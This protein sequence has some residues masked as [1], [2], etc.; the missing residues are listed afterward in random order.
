MMAYCGPPDRGNEQSHRYETQ[1][2]EKR[3]FARVRRQQPKGKRE[4]YR[5]DDERNLEPT[6]RSRYRMRRSAAHGAKPLLPESKRQDWHPPHLA[7]IEASNLD[8]DPLRAAS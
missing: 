2:P 6:P 5:D 7:Q 1:A 4:Q 8:G 3:T